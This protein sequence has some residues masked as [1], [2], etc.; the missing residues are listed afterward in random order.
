MH[1]LSLITLIVLHE[2]FPRKRWNLSR[3]LTSQKRPLPVSHPSSRKLRKVGNL[4]ANYYFYSETLFSN[5]CFRAD[6]H[7]ISIYKI[8]YLCCRMEV[9]LSEEILD[10]QTK[11]RHYL[12]PPPLYHLKTITVICFEGIFINY[13]KWK[14]TH[15]GPGRFYCE[16]HS[17][18]IQ[19]EMGSR[20]PLKSFM[21]LMICKKTL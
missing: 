2:T 20:F 10:L 6:G 16:E 14:R 3:F 9:L 15:L 13:W 12:I 7:R 11:A 17:L 1:H 4:F 19:G 18:L 21:W 8:F 5:L